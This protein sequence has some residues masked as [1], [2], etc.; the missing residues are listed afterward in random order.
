MMI[1]IQP[2]R[3]FSVTTTPEDGVLFGSQATFTYTFSGHFH[4]PDANGV[5]RAAGVLSEEVD[6]DNGTSY[7]CTSNNLS[8]SATGPG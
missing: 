7:H 4:G 2:D 3:S 6:F 1:P 5:E 8:W